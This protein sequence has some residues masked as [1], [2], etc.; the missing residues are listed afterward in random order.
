MAQVFLPALGALA[1]FSSPSKSRFRPLRK[2]PI[3]RQEPHLDAPVRYGLQK[4][5]GSCPVRCCHDPGCVS[6]ES[7]ALA[8]VRSLNLWSRGHTHGGSGLLKVAVGV[9]GMSAP[10]KS[11]DEAHRDTGDRAG[12]ISAMISS[13]R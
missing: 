7:A 5:S 3:P 13:G 2:P 1:T 12:Y 6:F 8:V 4:F 9:P 10:Q 11:R